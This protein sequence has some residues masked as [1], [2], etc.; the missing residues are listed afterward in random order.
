MFNLISLG[1]EVDLAAKNG[2]ED[3][4]E[5][6]DYMNLIVVIIFVFEL[7]APCL[8]KKYP[9]YPSVLCIVSWASR[10]PARGQCDSEWRLQICLRRRLSLEFL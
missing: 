6:F 1:I 5:I 7:A 3:V 8:H 4:P 10:F 9:V 2:Q